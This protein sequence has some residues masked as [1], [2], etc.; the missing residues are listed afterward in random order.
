MVH[1]GTERLV[2]WKSVE[3]SLLCRKLLWCS[4]KQWKMHAALVTSEP[5]EGKGNDRVCVGQN[6]MFLKVNGIN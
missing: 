4:S 1:G 6:R 2:L 3:D 5:V